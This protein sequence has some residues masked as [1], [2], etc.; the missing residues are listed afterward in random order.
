MRK[1]VYMI[2]YIRIIGT[3]KED[4]ICNS[5]DT[6]IPFLNPDTDIPFINPGMDTSTGG[7]QGGSTSYN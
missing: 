2:P 6:D 5:A 4:V 7:G 3:K 1:S